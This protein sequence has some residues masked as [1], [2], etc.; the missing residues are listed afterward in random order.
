[1]TDSSKDNKNNCFKK[2]LKNAVNNLTDR[3]YK[4]IKLCLK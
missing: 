3:R 4:E 1:M 2:E